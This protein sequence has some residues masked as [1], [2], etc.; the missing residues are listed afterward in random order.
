MKM[1]MH[2][3]DGHAVRALGTHNMFGVRREERSRQ[4]LDSPGV[5]ALD[6]VGD[7]FDDE[8]QPADSGLEVVCSLFGM[9]IDF[10]QL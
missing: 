3:L 8:G 1:K 2:E 6:R 10:H 9:R 7:V 5:E 4:K